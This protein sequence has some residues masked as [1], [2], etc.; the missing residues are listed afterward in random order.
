MSATRSALVLL[1]V[2][3]M[4]ACGSAPE[5]AVGR[6]VSADTVNIEGAGATFPYPVYTRWFSRFGDEAG[7]RIRYRSIGS[8]AGV[9]ALL[10]DSVDFAATDAPLDT[11]E[12]RRFGSRTI[13]QVPLVVGGAAVT[14]HIPSLPRQLRLDGETLADIFLGRITRWDDARLVSLNPDVSLPREVIRVITR[15]DTSG[16]SWILTDYL[17]RLSPAWAAGPGRSKFPRWPV[18]LGARGNEGV[19]AEIKVTAFS[20]GVVEAVYAMQNRLQSARVRNHAGAWVTPQTGAL[21][22]AANAMLSS[23]DDTVEFATSISDAP[24]EASYPIASLSWLIVPTQGRDTTH[25]RVMHEFVRW[26]LARGEDDALALGYA[27]L[28]EAMRETL[29]RAWSIPSR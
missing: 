4:G 2:C 28:P 29:L 1:L 8:G 5:P 16:T 17:T 12:R 24:G 3:G 15:A 27:P 25:I 9:R 10:G 22:A 7:V 23:M 26:A 11:A 18:G 19:A 20:I 13:R 21:R 6:T 14:Y